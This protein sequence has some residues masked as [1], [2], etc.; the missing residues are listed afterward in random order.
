L[1]PETLRISV[2]IPTLNEASIL[3]TTLS[4]V[5]RHAPHELI[6]V[7]GGSEDETMEIAL[8]H[9]SLIVESP[10]GRA[11]QMNAGAKIATG[12]VLLFL[13]ADSRVGSPCYRKMVSVMEN[14]DKIGGAFSLAIESDK[15]SLRLIS[16]IATLRSRYLHLVYGD[17]A[18]FVR[19]AT[20]REIGGFAPLPI[21]EDLEFFRRLRKK[22][23]IILLKE[24]ACTSA[25]RWLAEGITF[26]TLRNI[27]IATLFLLGFP[28]R[29]LSKWYLIIR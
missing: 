12:D 22:G 9:T 28:P 6:V 17:Q 23:P 24:K 19:A 16:L 3:E 5:G 2:V 25:R 8:R 14:G 26:T 1:T 29:V 18:I 20:F 15:I 13:H 7:D 21:C 27:A 10:P 4:E 11:I